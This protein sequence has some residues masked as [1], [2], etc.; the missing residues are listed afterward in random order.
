MKFFNSISGESGTCRISPDGIISDIVITDVSLSSQNY[1][2][3]DS[4]DFIGTHGW[5]DEICGRGPCA[6]SCAASLCAHRGQVI[7]PMPA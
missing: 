1:L 2:G 6:T 3:G 4:T 7:T 5:L